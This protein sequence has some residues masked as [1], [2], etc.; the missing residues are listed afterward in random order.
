[1]NAV[2]ARYPSLHSM[3]TDDV[4]EGDLRPINIRRDQDGGGIVFDC[5][6]V[7]PPSMEGRTVT[8]HIRDDEEIEWLLRAV[9]TAAIRRRNKSMAESEG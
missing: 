5:T 3:W 4:Y 8:I 1:M 7:Q 9:K 6:I 2:P